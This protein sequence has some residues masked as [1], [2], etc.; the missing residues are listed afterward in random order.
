MNREAFLRFIKSLQDINS[1]A[2]IELD[3]NTDKML[4]K[5]KTDNLTTFRGTSV[6][7][8][9]IFS[10]QGADGLDLKQEGV[11]VSLCLYNLSLL[12]NIINLYE[13]N[14]NITLQIQSTEPEE[15]ERNTEHRFINVNTIQF[16]SEKLQ[17]LYKCDYLS[18][19]DGMNDNSIYKHNDDERILLEWEMNDFDYSKITS[20]L[21]IDVEK[22]FDLK[23]D[24]T[25]ITMFGPDWNF[26]LT[27]EITK[28]TSEELKKKIV[29]SLFT[30]IGKKKIY[31]ITD[32][33]M[34]TEQ[35]FMIG[36]KESEN[37]IG[38]EVTI[39]SI[40]NID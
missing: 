21:K 19:F 39:V 9:E 15:Q 33:T 5:L 32:K 24:G 22:M 37:Q 2:M 1:M 23:Y 25:D 12:T 35:P 26:I 31:K 8:S 6:K 13:D 28:E 36:E 34:V 14:F 20:L 4:S 3:F 10:F 40:K 11:R 18:N 38:N 30:A 7:M 16:A 27:S 17:I 29:K